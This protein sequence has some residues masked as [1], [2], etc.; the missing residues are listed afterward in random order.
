MERG[1]S[2]VITWKWVHELIIYDYLLESDIF[3]GF[4]V[5]I[6]SHS[7]KI[8]FSQL[9]YLDDGFVFNTLSMSS[10]ICLRISIDIA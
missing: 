8:S 1:F 2:D 3:L 4:K 10:F 5:H 9:L 6:L 7:K